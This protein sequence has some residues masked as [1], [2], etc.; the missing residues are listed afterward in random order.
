LAHVVAPLSP[1]KNV[2][3]RE[4]EKK[5]EQRFTILSVSRKKRRKILPGKIMVII[6]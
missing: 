1:D 5:G 2:Q 4:A 6:C 3:N